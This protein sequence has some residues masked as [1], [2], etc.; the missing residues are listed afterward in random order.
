MSLPPGTRLGPYEVVSS[1]GVGGMGEVYR[2][3]DTRLGRAVAVKVLSS[4]LGEDPETVERF[5]RE[6]RLVAA[7]SHP[8]I[9]ALYDVGREGETAFAVMELLEGETLRQRLHRGPIA[10]R[11][12]REVASQLA[13][14]LAAAHGKGIVHRD[15]KPENVFL[16]TEGRVKVLDFGLARREPAHA[17]EPLPGPADTVR[18]TPGLVLGT[19]GYMSPEQV[20]GEVA[21]QRADIFAFGTILYELVTGERAFRRHSAVDT[22]ASILRDTPP[23]LARGDRTMPPDL[24]AV[25]A[26]CLEKSPERRFSSALE[27]G[28]ALQVTEARGAPPPVAYPPRREEPAPSIAI[29]PFRNLSP[30]RDAEY[31]CDGIT[32]EIIDALSRLAGLR[33]AA[34]T[35]SFAFRGRDEDVRRIGDALGVKTVMEGSVRVSGTRLRV[36]ARLID[37]T[38]GYPLWSERYDRAADDVFAVED[39]IARA[40]TGTLQLHLLGTP[41]GPLVERGTRDPEA[42]DLYLRGRYFF[43]RRLPPRAIDCFERAVARDP[44]YPAPYTGL[45][46]SYAVHA[47]YGGIPTLDA[48][49]RARAAALKARQLA[50]DA[51]ETH[52]SL[53]IL[54]HYFGWDF[55][56]QRAE[57]QEAIRIN[58]RS[59]SAYYWL[60]LLDNLRGRPEEGGPNARK[61]VELEPLS[62][63]AHTG[64]G[65]G[66]YTDSRF[67]E[68]AVEMRKG[69]D[70][71]PDAL[72]PVWSLGMAEERLGHGDAAVLH[73]EKAVEI[74]GRVGILLANLARGYVAAGRV[75]DARTVLLELRA[76]AA[77]EYV[78]PLHLAIAESA[79]GDLD[80]AVASLRKA[81]QERNA[82]TWWFARYDPAMEAVRSRPGFDEVLSA[83]VPAA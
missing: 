4:A 47:F 18:T 9:V 60:G 71:D 17:V 11:E 2:A 25:A 24:Q 1:L 61:A 48:F 30:E 22:L 80:D 40:I 70:I 72:F 42:Y 12:A 13:A 51:A 28:D 59:A 66:A 20:R 63:N 64:V 68:A 14:A 55:E 31:L 15:L 73:F 8:G 19:I 35:S 41:E 37:V 79:V 32:E 62:A 6:A 45:A 16:T 78:A 34:R 57:L 10:P 5:E 83:L 44:A 7:L 52:V 36:S 82:L 76:D 77:R 53:G 74:G 27:L 33:V 26:R 39:E 65:F 29:L 67:E 75:A 50:P 69:H 21:D 43:N 81:C 46:D 38:T 3:R 58:P 23:H 49:A 56:K 54:E